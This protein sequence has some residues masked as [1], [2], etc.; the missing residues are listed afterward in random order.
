MYSLN[1]AGSSLLSISQRDG[2]GNVSFV[3]LP[4]L[5]FDAYILHVLHNVHF[6][7]VLFRL[8]QKKIVYQKEFIFI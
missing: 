5:Q 7:F 4:W 1:V 6:S 2:A 3:I 8:K